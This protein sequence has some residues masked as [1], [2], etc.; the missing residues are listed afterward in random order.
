MDTN[1]QTTRIEN[2]QRAVETESA[3]RWRLQR[4]YAALKQQVD[5]LLY[6][7]GKFDDKP[8]QLFNA[9]RRLA[10]KHE[11]D[12]EDRAECVALMDYAYEHPHQPVRPL[13]HRA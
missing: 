13:K 11:A 7:V 12:P 9:L 6:C 2:L 5:D 1:E 4:E 3:E 8:H 10:E